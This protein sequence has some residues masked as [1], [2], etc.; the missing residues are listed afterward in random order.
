MNII[1][2]R[3]CTSL[4]AWATIAARDEGA[5]IAFNAGQFPSRFSPIDE[6]LEIGSSVTVERR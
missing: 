1:V 3:W 4:N 6:S 2:T 5:K